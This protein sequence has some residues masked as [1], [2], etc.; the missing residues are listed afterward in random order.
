MGNRDNEPKQRRL[1][2]A[3]SSIRLFV[4]VDPDFSAQPM[5][6]THTHSSWGEWGLCSCEEWVVT[7]VHYRVT[8][9]KTKDTEQRL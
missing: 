6:C 5:L 7:G 3:A 1:P 8:A 2:W 9:D 4:A